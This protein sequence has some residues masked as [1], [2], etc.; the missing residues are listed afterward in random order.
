MANKQIYQLTETLSVSPDDWLAIDLDASNVTRKV[1]VGNVFT[2]T[3][4]GSDTQIQYND[5]GSFGASSNLTFNGNDLS[6]GGDIGIGTGSYQQVWATNFSGGVGGIGTTSSHS[7]GIATAGTLG[8]VQDT[9]QQVTI[10]T[11]DSTFTNNR[12]HLRFNRSDLSRGIQWLA[13][14]GDLNGWAHQYSNDLTTWNTAYTVKNDGDVD[15]ENNVGIGT[16]SPSAKFHTNLSADV[17]GYRLDLSNGQIADAFQINSYGNTGGDLLYI[18]SSGKFVNADIIRTSYDGT[19]TIPAIQIGDSEVGLNGLGYDSANGIRII[20]G[21]SQTQILNK[22]EIRFKYWGGGAEPAL[23]IY[24]TDAVGVTNGR[25]S[26]LVLSGG[27][28]SGNANGGDIIFKSSSSGA[29]GTS[30]NS[31]VEVARITNSGNVGI[32]ATSIDASAKFQIDSTTQG[33]LLP[34]MTTTQRDAIASPATGLS[35]FNTSTSQPEYYSGTAWEGAAGG[36]ISIG[37]SIGGASVNQ[38]LFTDVSGL[39]AQNSKF[40]FNG[41]TLN[42]TGGSSSNVT[43]SSFGVGAGNSNSGNSNTSIGHSANGNSTGNGLTSVGHLSGTQA[44]SDFSVYIGNNSGYQSS[45]NRN[46]FSGYLSG[47]QNNGQNSVG[48]GDTALFSVTGNQNTAVGSNSLNLGGGS[49]H[50]ALGYGCLQYSSGNN[51]AAIGYFAG[52][53]QTG[54]RV[55]ALGYQAGQ[56]NSDNNVLIIGQSNLPQFAGAAAAAAALPAAGVNGVYLYWDTT[57]NTIKARP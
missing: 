28:S 32:G 25:G 6:V 50:V 13:Y 5:G 12:Y 16:T 3:P 30:L 23:G 1:R 33:A 35:I 43:N 57:D 45:G 49:G 4:A 11:D 26:S 22:T 24:A 38:V 48:I 7:F 42:F 51:N 10:N 41:S 37:D 55:L 31:L 21:G 34:R 19:T 46:V 40:I 9:N 39:L 14:R 18:T 29:S 27:R 36:G 17:V 15:F 56:N 54:S 47:Y 52:F 2:A 8:L 44:V 53:N 20:T